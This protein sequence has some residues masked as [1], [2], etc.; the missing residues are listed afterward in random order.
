MCYFN[1]KDYFSQH[2]YY[3]KWKALLYLKEERINFG[4]K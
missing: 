4:E 1:L 2:K 3:K